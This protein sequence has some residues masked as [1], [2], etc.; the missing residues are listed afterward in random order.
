[1]N[2][3]LGIL[4]WY[5]VV[6][7]VAAFATLMLHGALWV[8]FRTDGELAARC[9]EL[10]S[11]VWWVV[12]ALAAVITGLSFWI[13][14]QLWISFSARPWGFVFPAAGAVALVLVRVWIARGTSASFL[15]SCGFI[16]AML[17]SAA[18]GLYP[19][20]LVARGDGRFGLTVS[21]AA[22]AGYG[23]QAGV[24]WFLPG[25]VLVVGYFVF[26]YWRFAGKVDPRM[27]SDRSG[28]LRASRVIHCEYRSPT[29]NGEVDGYDR[30]IL[31]AADAGK[32]RQA[33]PCQEKR[34]TI[35]APVLSLIR[36]GRRYS[37]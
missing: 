11:R 2:G 32:I 37:G 1:M 22:A 13:Q 24:W 20:V 9:R 7:G 18:F 19:Y 30:G 33:L 25:M 5:T 28:D 31:W 34:P 35:H 16:A 3:E 8:A 14:P 6:V 23:L 10:A 26:T 29:V 36:S 4:D 21:N 12:V 15:A 17:V 27:D